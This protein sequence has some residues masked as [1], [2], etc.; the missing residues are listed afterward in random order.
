M[1]IELSKFSDWDSKDVAMRDFLNEN[2][3][4]PWSRGVVTL[5]DGRM[6]ACR[7]PQIATMVHPESTE[8]RVFATDEPY[9]WC[10]LDWVKS[11]EITDD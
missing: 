8:I 10:P 1:K 6:A 9:G 2:R 3:R 11:L 7:N 5:M 4:G